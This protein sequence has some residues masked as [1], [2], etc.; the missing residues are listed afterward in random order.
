MTLTYSPG[1]TI[2]N[3]KLLQCGE[4][5]SQYLPES[6]DHEALQSNCPLRDKAEE[7][8]S[9]SSLETPSSNLRQLHS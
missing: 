8:E 6:Q 3:E 2:A 5:K 1:E 4:S 7:R 9:G